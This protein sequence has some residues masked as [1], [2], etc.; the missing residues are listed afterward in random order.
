MSDHLVYEQKIDLPYRYTAGAAHRAFL[1]GL[2]ERRLV[3]SRA[4]SG[5]VFCPARPFAPDGRRLGETVELPARGTLL[6][7]T[8]ARHLPG[9]PSFGLILIEGSAT[10]LLH[11]L[12]EGAESLS[13]GSAVEPVWAEEPEPAVTAIAYFRPVP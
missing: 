11:R 3:G 7:A 12:G 6:A 10:P 5:D 2:A 1:C 4:E 9:E 13:P 8:V